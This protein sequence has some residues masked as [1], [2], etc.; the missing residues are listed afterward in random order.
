MDDEVW[1]MQV[2]NAM[3]DREAIVGRYN[4]FPDEKGFLYKCLGVL[5]RKSTHKQFVVKH[6]DSVFAT[7]KHSSQTEREV[8]HHI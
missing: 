2:G 3:G 8:R 4:T 6:L 5:M 7:V 1:L